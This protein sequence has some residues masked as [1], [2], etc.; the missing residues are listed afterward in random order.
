M[1]MRARAL[2][3]EAQR[4]GDRMVL[5][6]D[7]ADAGI[8]FVRHPQLAAVRREREAARPLADLD[9]FQQLGAG[10]VDHVH[11]VRHLGADV[12]RL[13]VARDL[14]AFGFLSDR[15]GLQGLAGGCIDE[16]QR[17]FVLL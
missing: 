15:H 17:A 8:E 3:L 2:E 11:Q 14:H 13:A 5:G 12:D 1:V 10:H 9:V 7:D 16:D 4:A 6:V